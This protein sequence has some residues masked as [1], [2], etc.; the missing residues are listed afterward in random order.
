[1]VFL[2]ICGDDGPQLLVEWVFSVENS[3]FI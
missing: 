1:L 2:M 3:Q